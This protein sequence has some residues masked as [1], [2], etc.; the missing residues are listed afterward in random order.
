MNQLT[1][2]FTFDPKGLRTIMDTL[3]ELMTDA[4][5][6]FTR[7]GL[8]VT[9]VDPNR[10]AMI[11][12]QLES[13]SE[14]VMNE[15]EE[16]F[17]GV[18]IPFLYKMLRYCNSTDKARFRIFSADK[19]VMILDVVNEEGTTT[20][21]SQFKNIMI[22]VDR[23]PPPQHDNEYSSLRILSSTLGKQLKEVLSISK[24]VKLR[25]D[26]TMFVLYASNEHSNV[27]RENRAAAY[28]QRVDD[29]V[30]EGVFIIRYLDKFLKPNLSDTITIRFGR[31][32]P[33]E[34]S[35]SFEKGSMRM[36]LSPV[37]WNF[38]GMETPS[39]Q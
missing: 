17:F 26:K 13:N 20:L 23:F 22:P 30:Y 35:H 25:F 3:R 14:M 32:L 5:L 36:K 12:L 29:S 39:Q 19:D 21:T 24:H 34:I 9:G 7:K 37:T 16:V 2:E 6:L 33:L 38:D 1:V 27:T 10:L 18:Y 11:N 4:N 8:E 15:N 31:N 28:F